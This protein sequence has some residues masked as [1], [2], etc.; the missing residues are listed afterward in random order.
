[1]ANQKL[2]E[3]MELLKKIRKRQDKY[4]KDYLEKDHDTASCNCFAGEKEKM[5][6]H[7]ELMKLSTIIDSIKVEVGQLA[8]MVEKQEQYLDDFSSVQFS[9]FLFPPL[10]EQNTYINVITLRKKGHATKRNNVVTCKNSIN[11]TSKGNG[12]HGCIT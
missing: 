6:Q 3:V 1:M 4:E 11:C 12:L 2:D 9:R 8:E 5:Q 10:V 7:Q